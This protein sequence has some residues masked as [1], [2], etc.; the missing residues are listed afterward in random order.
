MGINSAIYNGI[1]DYSNSYG[2]SSGDL[3]GFLTSKRARPTNAINIIKEIM[4]GHGKGNLLI[5]LA[6]MARVERGVRGLEP[7]MRDHVVH[8]LLSYITGIFVNERILKPGGHGVMPFQWQLAGLFHDVGYPT[9]VAKGI[10][11]QFTRQINKIRHNLAVTRADLS[12][13]FIPEGLDQLMGNLNSLDLI[14]ESLN[15][16]GLAINAKDEYQNMIRSDRIC[17]GMISSLSVLYVIDM[18]Y[19]KNNPQRNNGDFFDSFEIDPNSAPLPFLLKLSDC[20]QDWERPSAASAR[21]VSEEKYDIQ[22]AGQRLIFTVDDAD[23]RN[24]IREEI[25]ASLISSE[26]EVR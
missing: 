21:G 12:F 22:I 15:G 18:M 2:F 6:E 26:I 3:N 13:R 9:E 24:K 5:C 17:H 23:R 8:A 16:W 14:Q 10:M 20:L 11:Q 4:G 19:Q 25:S 1:K 7:W